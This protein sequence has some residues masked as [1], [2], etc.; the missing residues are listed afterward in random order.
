M[1]YVGLVKH[2]ALLIRHN[3]LYSYILEINTCCDLKKRLKN[4]SL[5]CFSGMNAM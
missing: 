4:I 5:D 1:V 3:Y 2:L